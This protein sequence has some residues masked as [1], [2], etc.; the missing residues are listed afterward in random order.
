LAALIDQNRGQMAQTWV[1]EANYFRS[2]MYISSH[3][4]RCSYTC[5]IAVSLGFCKNYRFATMIWPKDPGNFGRTWE[6]YINVDIHPPIFIFWQIGEYPLAEL[7]DQNKGTKG[8][9]LGRRG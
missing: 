4:Y 3:I 9:D 2:P 7:I 1:G 6:M 8:P 5:N